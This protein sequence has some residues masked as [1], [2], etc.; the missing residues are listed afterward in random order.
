LDSGEYDLLLQI[1]D[2]TA[3]TPAYAIRLANDGLW[4]SSTGYNDLDYSLQINSVPPDGDEEEDGEEEIDD[5]EDDRCEEVANVNL[6]AGDTFSVVISGTTACSGYSQLQTIG[7]VTLGDSALAVSFVGDYRPPAGTQFVIIANDGSATIN[8]TFAGLPEGARYNVGG[9]VLQITYRGGDGNDAVLSAVSVPATPNTGIANIGAIP[10]ALLAVTLL[11]SV[12]I[13][14][15]A[16]R[17]VKVRQTA[18]R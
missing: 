3:S 13:L 11:T 15:T 10:R 18:E 17:T 1:S 16:D 4:E 7:T 14:W 9:A 2:D 5:E 8:G 6:S 12:F